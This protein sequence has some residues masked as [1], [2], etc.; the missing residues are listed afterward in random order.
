MPPPTRLFDG[1]QSQNDTAQWSA[2]QP[3][4]PACNSCWAGTGQQLGIPPLQCGGRML[5]YSPYNIYPFPFMHQK[6]VAFTQLLDNQTGVPIA[7]AAPCPSMSGAKTA[8]SQC[9]VCRLDDPR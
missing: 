1:E 5:Y 4:P 3:A 6:N 2:T 8:S 7:G 9:A